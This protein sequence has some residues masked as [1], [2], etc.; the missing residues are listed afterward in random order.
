M[1]YVV[2]VWILK[3]HKMCALNIMKIKFNAWKVGRGSVMHDLD[4]SKCVMDGHCV[5]K[6]HFPQC[7]ESLSPDPKYGE[8]GHSPSTS[9]TIRMR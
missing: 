9:L 4:P 2:I 8:S 7:G 1:L 3:S 6:G 5:I